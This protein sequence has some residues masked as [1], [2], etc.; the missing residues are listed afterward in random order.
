[1]S[2]EALILYPPSIV[3]AILFPMLKDGVKLL[4]RK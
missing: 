2:G 1:M 4:L 3:G